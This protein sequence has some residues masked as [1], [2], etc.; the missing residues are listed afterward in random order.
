MP[1]ICAARTILELVEKPNVPVIYVAI[2]LVSFVVM[3][4]IECYLSC[5][6]DTGWRVYNARSLSRLT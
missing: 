2:S 5:S 6:T 3:I 1:V 4:N